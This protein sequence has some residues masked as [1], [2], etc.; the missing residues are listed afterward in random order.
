M[1]FRKNGYHSKSKD[2]SGE[3]GAHSTETRGEA[4]LFYLYTFFG[5]MHTCKGQKSM[6]WVPLHQSHLLVCKE[7]LNLGLYDWLD[8]LAS[9]PRIPF[10]DRVTDARKHVTCFTWTLK[11]RTQ[12]FTLA[13]SC[14]LE[15]HFSN[16]ASSPGWIMGFENETSDEYLL[17]VAW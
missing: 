12:A 1:L 17:L 4:V 9:E 2:L 7:T 5:C 14:V 3:K 15:R 8:W 11:T 10:L 13:Q 16:R 6:S